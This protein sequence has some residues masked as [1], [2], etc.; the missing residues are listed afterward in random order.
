MGIEALHALLQEGDTVSGAHLQVDTHLWDRLF[1]RIKNTPAIS[2]LRLKEATRTSFKE[3]T[4][5]SI[6]LLQTLYFSFA[7]VVAFGVV[8]NSARIALSERSR[9]LATLRVLGFTHAEVS[10]V[11]IG[12]LSLLTLAAIPAGLLFGSKLS[13]LIIAKVNTESVRLPL[14]L[15]SHNF[16]M[17]ATIVLV[18]AALSFALVSRRI[19]QLDLLAVL[20]AAE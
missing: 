20:K 9:D 8:Y 7:V 17:A 3:T 19:R 11:L 16:A 12:E 5:E 2:V 15:T 14:I 6:N 10:S 18:S 13:H 1:P 4:A